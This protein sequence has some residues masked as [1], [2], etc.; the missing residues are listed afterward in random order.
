MTNTK[1]LLFNDFCELFCDRMYDQRLP[2]E[3]QAT[4]YKLLK[5]MVVNKIQPASLEEI[6]RWENNPTKQELLSEPD[7]K[8][9]RFLHV[10]LRP[11]IIRQWDTIKNLEV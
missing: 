5:H 9:L 4:G 8:Y 1:K 2:E 10:N 11:L 6:E 7:I 3:S